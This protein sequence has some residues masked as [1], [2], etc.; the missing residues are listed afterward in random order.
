MV[1][2]QE[3]ELFDSLR[4]DN[5]WFE[6]GVLKWEP[7]PDP[8]DLIGTREDGTTVGVELTEW[9]DHRQASVSIRRTEVKY[10]FWKALNT[11]APA[12]PRNCSTVQVS[13]KEGVRLNRKHEGKFRAEFFKLIAH[14]DKNWELLLAG[15]PLPTWTDFSGYPTVEKY[16][17]GLAFLT[18]PLNRKNEKQWVIF[19]GTGG[20]YSPRWAAEALLTRIRTKTQYR[21]ISKTHGL[22]E[23]VLVVHYGLKGI[24]HNTPYRGL[25]FALEDILRE[26][27]SVLRQNAGPFQRVYLYLAFN[28]GRLIE[29]WSDSKGKKDD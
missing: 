13:L 14:L 16:V 5:P 8:P 21:G 15:F 29:I 17:S 27:A 10:A 22:S 3:I 19:E 23:L 28:E 7:G 12:C 6:S 9:L 20:P 24:L 2:K 4:R 1:K 26:P 18:L 25:N 11:N